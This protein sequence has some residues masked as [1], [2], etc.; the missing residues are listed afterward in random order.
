MSTSKL[1][2]SSSLASENNYLF[3]SALVDGSLKF[4][5]PSGKHDSAK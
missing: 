4:I 2:D 1:L 3:F 5:T